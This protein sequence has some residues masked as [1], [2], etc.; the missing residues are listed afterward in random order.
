MKRRCYWKQLT[1][2]LV[3]QFDNSGARTWE[4]LLGIERC[5]FA[6][7]TGYWMRCWKFGIGYYIKRKAALGEGK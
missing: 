5:T 6:T 4:T 7:E 1:T 2:N 3:V